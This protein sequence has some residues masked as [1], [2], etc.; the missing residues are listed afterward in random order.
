MRAVIISIQKAQLYNIAAPLSGLEMGVCERTVVSGAA[1]NRCV[2]IFACEIKCD[3]SGQRLHRV[4]VPAKASRSKKCPHRRIRAVDTIEHF[5]QTS[6]R[7]GPRV[8]RDTARTE[9]IHPPSTRPEEPASDPAGA[10]SSGL[11]RA[12]Q[13][14]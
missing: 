6:Q 8:G 2:S 11:R 14:S 13:H 1:G 10:A 9:S 5:S 12:S 7:A 3:A 4:L